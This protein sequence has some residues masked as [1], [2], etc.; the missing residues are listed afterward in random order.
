[1]KKL[2][3]IMIM[4][5]ALIP[6]TPIGASNKG[7]GEGYKVKVIDSQISLTP[8]LD[9]RNVSSVENSFQPVKIKWEK[10]I[11]KIDRTSKRLAR[12]GIPANKRARLLSI[13]LLAYG[14][15]R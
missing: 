7:I 1:M 3:L 8:A 12:R 14:G 13:L 10:G 9:V 11:G 4:A 6:V 2:L 5:I 15:K